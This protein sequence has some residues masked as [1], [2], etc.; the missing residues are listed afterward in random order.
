MSPLGSVASRFVDLLG[1]ALHYREVGDGPPVLFLHGNPTSSFLWRHVLARADGSHRYLALDLVGMGRSGKPDLEY[2]L[3]D[4]IAHVDAFIDALELRDAVLVGHDW[5]VTI[6]L[7]RLRRFPDQVRGVAF[8]EGH[9]RPPVRWDVFDNGG[10]ELFEQLRT[11]GVGERLA[12]DDNV[13]VDTVLPAGLQRRL[14][15]AEL[16]SYRRPYPDRASRRPLLQWAREIPIE[17]QPDDVAQLMAA[18]A[19]HLHASPVPKLLVHAP[20]GA[21]VTP[22]VVDWCTT[23]LSNLSAVDVGRPAGHFLPEDRP[24]EVAE[25]LGGWLRSLP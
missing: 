7:D 16:A 22:E 24:G 25:A 15:P 6:A 10:R 5:G 18:A 12:L 13:L 23:Q 14:Q 3:A 21:L 17:G 1:T 4:H 8:M 11:T 19:R 9:L 2:R 20:P